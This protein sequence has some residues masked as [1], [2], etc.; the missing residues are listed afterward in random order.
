MTFFRCCESINAL[1][2]SITYNK[3]MQKHRNDPDKNPAPTR[4][5]RKTR[6][7]D[8]H[9][10]EESSTEDTDDDHDTGGLGRY[11]HGTVCLSH[12][13]WVRQVI[14]AGCFGVH[15]TQGPEA[16]HKKCV[17]LASSR[18]RHYRA[19]DTRMNMHWD[20]KTY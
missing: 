14:A 12:Q 2:A 19:N 17:K 6:S 3:R 9:S 13:H 7:W 20:H 10:G 1:N 4:F 18:V 5:K 16:F 11:S 8:N 15:N